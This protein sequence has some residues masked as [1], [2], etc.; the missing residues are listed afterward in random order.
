MRQEGDS[1]WERADRVEWP[2]GSHYKAGET[3]LLSGR[4]REAGTAQKQ[5]ADPG[6]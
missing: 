1:R 2:W 3:C 4:F 6:T 5:P